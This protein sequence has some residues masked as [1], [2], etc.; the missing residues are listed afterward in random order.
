[1]LVT[2]TSFG[3]I[4]NRRFGKDVNDP[5][6]FARAAYYNTTG[7]RVADKLRH[8]WKVGGD[9]RFYGVG[10]G[11]NP[12]CP[13]QALQQTFEC[14]DPVVWQGNNRVSVKRRA[15]TSKSDYYLIVTTDG[16]TGGIAVENEDWKAPEV[17]LIS[18]SQW[19]EQQEIMLLMPAYS[20]I[21]GRLGTFFAEP[22]SNK[23]LDGQLRLTCST[24]G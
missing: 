11:F 21:K 7:I 10:C 4:W 22:S 2:I 5:R 12:H 8:R 17:I 20:W 15:N 6:R 23:T 16:Q 13:Q 9:L 18:F 1:M 14:Y 3:S 24:E 19:K